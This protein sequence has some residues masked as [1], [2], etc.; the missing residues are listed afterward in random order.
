VGSRNEEICVDNDNEGL[1]DTVHEMVDELEV[2]QRGEAIYETKHDHEADAGTV[3]AFSK[4]GVSGPRLDGNKIPVEQSTSSGNY[5]EE[6]PE[7]EMESA[8]DRQNGIAK[9]GKRRN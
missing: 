9:Y 6:L 5:F 7:H 1:R 8:A 3:S 4:F 2:D